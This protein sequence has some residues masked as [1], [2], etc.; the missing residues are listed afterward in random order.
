VEAKTVETEVVSIPQSEIRNLRLRRKRR[1][2]L[3]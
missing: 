3:Y 1:P 2:H